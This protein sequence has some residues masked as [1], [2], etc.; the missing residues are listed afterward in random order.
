LELSA[1]PVSSGG[2]PPLPLPSPFSRPPLLS[3]SSFSL[4]SFG[5]L[6]RAGGVFLLGLG[7][8]GFRWRRGKGFGSMGGRGL[9][10]R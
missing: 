7:N 2:L 6:V 9:G 3:L 8:L 4:S 5:L 10:V 1:F